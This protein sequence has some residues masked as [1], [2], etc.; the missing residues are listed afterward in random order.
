[1]TTNIKKDIS[2]TVNK[3][4]TIRGTEPVKT[5]NRKKFSYVIIENK[6]IGG[7]FMPNKHFTFNQI[8]IVCRLFVFVLIIL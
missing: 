1:M 5:D 4:S 6:A 2:N 8:L 7:I 3:S